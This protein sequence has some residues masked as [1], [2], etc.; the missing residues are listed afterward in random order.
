MVNRPSISWCRRFCSVKGRSLGCRFNGRGPVLLDAR[1]PLWLAAV[2]LRPLPDEEVVVVEERNETIRDR[3]LE[4]RLLSREEEPEA[5]LTAWGVSGTGLRS[6]RL[7]V[8]PS[9]VHTEED[10]EADDESGFWK[11][12]LQLNGMVALFLD[13]LLILMSMRDQFF[14][15]PRMNFNRR[16]CSVET[17]ER[18]GGRF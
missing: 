12:R 2:L 8:I 17:R 7:D 3:R 4:L 9:S 18:R 1:L 11:R 5:L 16:D 6:P 15:V 13:D 14:D 10:D